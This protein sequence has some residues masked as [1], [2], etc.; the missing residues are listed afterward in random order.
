[1]RFFLLFIFLSVHF[2]F[3]NTNHLNDSLAQHIWVDSL[4]KNLTIEEKIGQ[5]FM[6]AAYSNKSEKHISQISDL[7]INQ[8]IGGLMFMQGGPERQIHLTN[9]YQKESDIPLLIAQDAEWGL[10]MRIDSTMR[11]PWQMTLGAVQDTKLIYQMGLEIARQCKRIGVHINFAP[12]VDVNSNPKNPIINNRSFG[13]DP[14]NVAKLSNA[15]MQGLQDG[16]IIACAKHFPGHGD[17]D[18]DSHKTLPTVLH[19]LERLDSIDLVPFKHL[20][21]N[22][23][24]AIMVAHLYFPE[25][26]DKDS[27]PSS[28]SKKIVTD[29]LKDKLEFNGLIVTDA[30]NMKGVSD[31]Y[32]PG[33]VDLKA[34]LA[35]NDIL[36][37]SQDV[38]LAIDKIKKAIE[39]GII[40]ESEVNRRCKKI[41]KA[42]YSLGLS[43]IKPI[44]S[45]NLIDDLNTNDAHEL[46]NKLFEKSITLLQNSKNIIPLKRLDTLKIAAVCIGENFTLYQNTINNY[47]PV[48]FYYLNENHTPQ[49]RKD[50]LIKLSDYN[51]VLASVH[52][53]NKNPWKNYNINQDVDLFLQTLAIQSKVILSVFANPYSLSDLLVT[54]AFDGLI[55]AYQNSH[56]TQSKVA[57][58]IFG[59]I[60]LHGKLPVSNKH[61][62]YGDGIIQSKKIRLTYNENKYLD[63]TF[64]KKVDSIAKNS[65]KEKAFPGCQIIAINNGEVFY[66]KSFGYHTYKKKKKVLNTDLYDIASITKIA[67]SVLSLMKLDEQGKFNFHLSLSDYI[68]LEDTS[69]K[70]D[71]LL[72]DILT[73]QS[74]LKPW[75]PF[76]KSTIDTNG[77]LRDTL[78]S[79]EKSDTFS[80]QVAQGIYLHKHYEDSILLQIDRSDLLKDSSYKYSDLGFYF[81]KEIIEKKSQSSL[82]WFIKNTF[83]NKLGTSTIGY[84]PK[85]YFDTSR[86]IPTE[87]DYYFRSQLLVGDVH[88]MGA[89]ML[90]GVGGHAGL[91]SNA[92]DLAIFLEMLNKKGIYGDERYLEKTTIDK[93][94][95]CFYC[96]D[97]NRRGLGFDKPILENQIGGPACDCSPSL[98][99]FGHS[100]FT[101]TLAWVDP[102][103]DFV[104]VFLSNRIHPSADNK[105]ILEKNIRTEIMHEFYNFI[106]SKNNK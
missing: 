58:S 83:Y 84:L 97:D 29:F 31:Y 85:L 57:Q 2:C 39:N 54:Y 36:L 70:K 45:K 6:V 20:I 33:E 44:S 74:G 13:E 91:F 56:I 82:D 26:D 10:S 43:K 21:N 12:V 37:F 99:S 63:N 59:G 38:P 50:L 69:N 22:D 79:F 86:I 7:V 19:N 48:D 55:M 68:S 30:L 93:Y 11:F 105:K 24:G 52:K 42:K 87:L 71:L 16:N 9:K 62:K 100:G 1:M 41:L 89:A 51:L 67:A 47:A 88:D 15:Y 77:N 98:N 60:P 78:Y 53:S 35:G 17:T 18:M 40:D 90:G 25:L 95:S 103:E 92:N 102:D 72:K 96:D 81:I 75:I 66:N 8:K 80:I 5:L 27:I 104:Y 61:F 94:T 73:H 23:V 34:F 14:F 76:Y 28:L 46:K 101:G 65:I 64:L 32:S 49:Q 3:A 4:M 106:R